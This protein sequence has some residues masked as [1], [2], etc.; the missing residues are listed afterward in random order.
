LPT[1][2][3]T[4]RPTLGGAVAWPGSAAPP[5]SRCTTRV[6]LPSRRPRRTTRRRSSPRVRRC[7]AGSTDAWARS[8]SSRGGSD[9]QA[10]AAL[11][12]T[13]RQ[14]RAPG[15]GAHAQPESVHLV[16]AAVVRLVR[17]LAHD[18]SPMGQGRVTPA[19]R[20]DRPLASGGADGNDRG[21]V[22]STGTARPRAPDHPGRGARATWTCG[23]RR[24]RVTEERYARPLRQVKSRGPGASEPVDSA[25]PGRFER[26]YVRTSSS[27]PAFGSALPLSPSRHRRQWPSSGL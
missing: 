25:L 9:R 27:F 11:A 14:D 2:R 21:P 22:V 15:A 13:C 12:A 18:I 10:L 4:T 16:A 6:S 26:R 3:P 19:L 17:T 1:A 8:R 20:S 7:C 23:T 24:H 5:V